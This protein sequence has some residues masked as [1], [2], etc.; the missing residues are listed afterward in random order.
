MRQG[1]TPICVHLI[2]HHIFPRFWTHFLLTSFMDPPLDRSWSSTLSSI[3]LIFFG[4]QRT[5]KHGRLTAHYEYWSLTRGLRW[6]SRLSIP[7]SFTGENQW[8]YVRRG[9]LEWSQR[10][11]VL[12]LL[13]LVGFNCPFAFNFPY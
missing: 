12:R 9:S 13:V 11:I 6:L 3:R 1:K 10:E 2:A 8:N 7:M 5:L 4:R